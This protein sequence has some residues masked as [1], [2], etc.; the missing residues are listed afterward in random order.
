MYILYYKGLDPTLTGKHEYS[1][2][3]HCFDV[4]IEHIRAGFKTRI[5]DDKGNLLVGR[6][7]KW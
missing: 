4:Y 2:F 5:Y 3:D 6:E 1:N 7:D